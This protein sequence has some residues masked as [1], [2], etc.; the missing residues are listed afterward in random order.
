MVH[1]VGRQPRDQSHPQ[2][3]AFQA[4][5]K[6]TRKNVKIREPGP[7]N[8]VIALYNACRGPPK[9]SISATEP[10][11]GGVG[12]HKKGD[13]WRMVC[14]TG[15][16]SVRR[17]SFLRFL[18][19]GRL[20]WITTPIG[21][22]LSMGTR[23]GRGHG[24]TRRGRGHG[25]PGAS[26]QGP[27]DFRKGE[28]RELEMLAKTGKDELKLLV[29]GGAAG[30]DFPGRF[31]ISALDLGEGLRPWRRRWRAWSRSNGESWSG[32]GPRCVPPPVP[33][34]RTNF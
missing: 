13:W 2:A 19:C 30:V 18:S 12:E 1:V 3:G 27:F 16:A 21:M 17:P 7:L 26:A 9:H 6:Q 25:A 8:A 11:G 33:R 24:Q 14:P 32:R 29:T 20:W 15:E 31:P 28:R 22:R 34:P 10:M 5:D 4:R 23:R